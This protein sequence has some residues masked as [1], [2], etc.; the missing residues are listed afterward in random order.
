MTFAIFIALVFGVF[1]ALL[2]VLPAVT[3]LPLSPGSAIASIISTMRAWDFLFPIHEMLWLVGVVISFEVAQWFWH[4]SWRVVKFLR[5][6][7]DGA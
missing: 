4:V 3:A 2:N 6:H 1:I 7:S 5:G